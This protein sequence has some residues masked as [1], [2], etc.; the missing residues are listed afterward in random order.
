MAERRVP[1]SPDARVRT[2]FDAAEPAVCPGVFREH[3]PRDVPDCFGYDLMDA[4][5]FCFPDPPLGPRAGPN[6]A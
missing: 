2:G 1:E 4:A 5:P 3:Q 6:V